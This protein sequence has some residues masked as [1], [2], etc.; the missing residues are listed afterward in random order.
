MANYRNPTPEERAQLEA[1]FPLLKDYPNC[2]RVTGEATSV[3][4]CM[5][6]C[7][8]ITDR[9][10]Y[11]G[12]TY[13][14]TRGILVNLYGCSRLGKLAPGAYIDYMR[15]R[16]GVSMHVA[17]NYGSNIGFNTDIYESKLGAEL[18][19]THRRQALEDDD[20]NLYGTVY[21]SFT[22]RT[23]TPAMDFSH[24]PITEVVLTPE[25]KQSL[26]LHVNGIPG[27]V[28]NYFERVF[29]LWIEYLAT[30]P[31]SYSSGYDIFTQ[32][33]AFDQLM[34]MGNEIIPLVLEKAVQRKYYKAMY[35]YEKLQGENPADI[36]RPVVGTDPIEIFLE[37]EHNRAVRTARRWLELQH[38]RF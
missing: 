33:E 11:M 7:L 21:D 19:I 22:Q 8:G 10:I 25:E 36:V 1:T 26:S 6:Y 14:E 16:G 34:T 13:E 12:F 32:G 24:I 35:L 3:Y 37:G 28:R 30:P 2:L 27:D 9:T 4:D 15:N 5:A 31:I 17:R 29:L 20:T 18:R 38:P 23:R